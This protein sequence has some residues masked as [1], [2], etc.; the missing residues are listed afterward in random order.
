MIATIFFWILIVS[1]AILAW[2]YA[3]FP[4]VLFILAKL[5][6][7]KH[8]M[9][10]KFEPK[11][12]LMIMTYNEAKTIEAKL[13]NSLKLKY[14]KNKLEIFVVDSA[15]DDGTAQI[16]KRFAKKHKNVRLIQQKQ[17]KG[18]ASA[19]NF[20]MKYASG[21]IVMITD[22]NAMMHPAALKKIVR[23]FVDPKVGGV[24]GRFEA[25]NLKGTATA[26]GGGIYWKIE[27]FLRK[28]E[29]DLDSCIH[30]SGEITS[31]RKAAYKKVDEQ[32]LTEDFDMA[33]N[34]RRRG[35]RIIYEPDAVVFE[36]APTSIQDL[37]IQKKRIVIGTW[38][39][40]GKY[41]CMLFNPKYGW[42]GSMII[43]SHKL[44]QITT[45]FFFILVFISTVVTYLLTQNI[46][47]FYFLAIQ[48]VAYILAAVSYPLTKTN[49]FKNTRFFV[50]LK[51]FTA[52]NLICLQG[53]FDF[54]RKKRAVTWKKIESSR[55][56]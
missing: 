55:E 3:G 17:R 34:L 45:P 33:I 44:F 53:F 49:T 27:K 5:F 2:T 47:F 36:P 43:P 16:A 7:K 23:H 22:G 20:G 10:N 46:L 1:L 6:K 4:I 39:T 37:T 38:Q 21:D 48:A 18:K 56:F 52:V 11:A 32:S 14:P 35:Y 29:S 41:K 24:C 19:I 51:Y 15:S 31:L 42:Y 13:K 30:M 50:F 9:S 25:R 8:K 28:N 54:V 26:A 12:T 40:L